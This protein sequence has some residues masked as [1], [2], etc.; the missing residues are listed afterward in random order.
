VLAAVEE[1]RLESKAAEP[2][3]QE[4]IVLGLGPCCRWDPGN[5]VGGSV[6]GVVQEADIMGRSVKVLYGKV[7]ETVRLRDA[8]PTHHRAGG[9][10][11]T[12]PEPVPLPIQSQGH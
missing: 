1:G 11:F 4:E 2:T 7:G 9:I 10:F 3:A 12:S 8:A 6:E 5:D